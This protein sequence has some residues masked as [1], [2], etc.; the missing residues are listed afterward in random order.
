MALSLAQTKKIDEMIEKNCT[1]DE[2]IQELLSNHKAQIKDVRKYLAQNKTL[3]GILKTIS[4][5]TNDIIKASDQASRTK[6]A[7][8]IKEL[9]KRGIKIAQKKATS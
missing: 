5:R 4:H 7:N 3:Q 8:G 6:L 2:I 1:A 9:A